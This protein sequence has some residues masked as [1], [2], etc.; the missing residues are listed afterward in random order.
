MIQSCVIIGWGEEGTRGQCATKS[1]TQGHGLVDSEPNDPCQ[2]A[3]KV[4][5]LLIP[6]G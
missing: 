3:V 5:S 4:S 1:T 6:G 2:V